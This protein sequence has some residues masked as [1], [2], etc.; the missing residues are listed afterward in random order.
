MQNALQDFANDPQFITDLRR[1]LVRKAMK[2]W[3]G[4]DISDFGEGDLDAI[5]MDPGVIR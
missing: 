3:G 5:R 2:C 4:E 1:P